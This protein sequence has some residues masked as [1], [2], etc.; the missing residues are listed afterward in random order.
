MRGNT[1]IKA[2]ETWRT[3]MKVFITLTAFLYF[4]LFLGCGGEKNEHNPKS[5]N[6]SEKIKRVKVSSVKAVP[7]QSSVSY[8]GELSAN[9]KVKVAT[10]IGGT[11]EKLFF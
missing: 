9:L 3:S 8:V 6:P 4:L 1:E 10:E 11:I 2:R 7:L 5:V